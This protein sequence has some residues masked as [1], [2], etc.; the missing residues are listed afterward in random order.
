MTHIIGANDTDNYR[1]CLPLD[2]NG[3]TCPLDV[4]KDLQKD[5]HWYRVVNQF[6]HVLGDV[7]FGNRVVKGDCRYTVRNVYEDTNETGRKVVK[8]RTLH[9]DNTIELEEY[10]ETEPGSTTY[11]ELKRI[12][13]DLDMNAVEFP[14]H[15]YPLYNPSTRSTDIDIH[16]TYRNTYRIGK[17]TIA[18]QVVP[19]TPCIGRSV[20]L[21]GRRDGRRIADVATVHFDEVITNDTFIEQSAG[22]A[23]FVPYDP[24]NGTEDIRIGLIEDDLDFDMFI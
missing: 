14:N 2:L 15:V 24:N 21:W 16:P 10:V 5:G 9:T 12:P 18:Q 6:T 11:V 4:T 13:I 7:T 22:H 17:V 1:V 19:D 20:T 3:D 8:V 23:N